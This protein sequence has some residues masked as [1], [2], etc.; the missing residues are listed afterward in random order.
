MDSF[1]FWDEK[2]FHILFYDSTPLSVEHILTSRQEPSMHT[3]IQFYYSPVLV[4]DFL[5]RSPYLDPHDQCQS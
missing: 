4:D 3:F 2:H 5:A 1:H